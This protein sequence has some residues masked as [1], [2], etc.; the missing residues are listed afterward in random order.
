ML[1]KMILKVEERET[2]TEPK[3]K[4]LI[5]ATTTKGGNIVKVKFQ[6]A[7]KNLPEEPGTYEAIFDSEQSNLT[8]DFY[9]M[10]MWVGDPSFRFRPAQRVDKVK[11]EFEA[12]DE[13]DLPF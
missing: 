6:K 10:V 9:G 2:K 3:K 5:F 8:R 13:N 11:D 7:V 4:F 1:T 12:V